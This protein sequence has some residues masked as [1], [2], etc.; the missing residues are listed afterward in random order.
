MKDVTTLV[1]RIQRKGNAI[2]T[3]MATLELRDAARK[4]L[5]R[6]DLWTQ[7]ISIPAIEE[8]TH[9]TIDLSS[10]VTTGEDPLVKKIL[11]VKYRGTRLDPTAYR[12]DRSTQELVM[13]QA[14]DETDTAYDIDAVD[15]AASTIT[16]S[17]DG[18]LTEV[19]AA[20]QIVVIEDSTN[21]DGY[22]RIVSVSYTS[23]NFVITLDKSVTAGGTL[24]TVTGGSIVALVHV[25]PDNGTVQFPDFVVDEYDYALIGHA[26]YELMSTRDRPYYNPEKA[27]IEKREYSRGIVDGRQRQDSLG[28][29]RDGTWT[30]Y[31]DNIGGLQG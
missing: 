13:R 18:D 7:D 28:T 5:N 14:P 22:Y 29:T 21:N 30:P 9:Y 12:L 31:E 2:P 3:N 24:G 23:P 26:A 6:V 15:A 1:P 27:V 10:L 4:F 16:I 17:G 8:Q 20:E 11:E 19:F 25:I